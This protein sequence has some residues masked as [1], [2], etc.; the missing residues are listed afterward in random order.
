MVYNVGMHIHVIPDRDSPPT[1]LL[2]ESARALRSGGVPQT[3][4]GAQMR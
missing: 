4:V 2:R 1:V 3:A